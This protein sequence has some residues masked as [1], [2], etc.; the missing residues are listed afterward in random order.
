[1]IEFSEEL[2]Q[3]V[4]VVKNLLAPLGRG[5]VLHHG[6]IESAL[7]LD[8]DCHRYRGVMKKVIRDYP[9]H[10]GIALWGDAV[11]CGYR[12][13]TV[14]EQL[15]SLGEMRHRAARR[16]RRGIREISALR[17]GEL[18]DIQ[19][20]AVATDIGRARAELREFRDAE[21]TRGIIMRPRESQPRPVHR[22]GTS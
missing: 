18:T 8:R 12:L 14:G 22:R 2:A 4:E 6:V 1:M 20:Y 10:R 16:I 19:R 5:D 17:V 11:A 15:G 13:L 3:Q 7:G 21:R 9:E